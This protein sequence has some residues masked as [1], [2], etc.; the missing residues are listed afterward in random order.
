MILFFRSPRVSLRKRDDYSWSK[1]FANLRSGGRSFPSLCSVADVSAPSRRK[2]A[3]RRSQKF[4]SVP[5]LGFSDSSALQLF[6]LNRKLLPLRKTPKDQ[7]HKRSLSLCYPIRVDPK[8]LSLTSCF[9]DMPLLFIFLVQRLRS[10][11]NMAIFS[12]CWQVSTPFLC[13]NTRAF[14][15]HRLKPD[16]FFQ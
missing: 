14:R 13:V 6:W 9:S 11:Q 12:C 4:P 16:Y 3:Y 10:N 8:S 7:C 5:L 1:A 15:Q 2:Y